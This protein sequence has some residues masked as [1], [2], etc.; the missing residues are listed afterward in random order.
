MVIAG[1]LGSLVH[2]TTSFVS[3]VGNRSFRS[4]WILWYYLRPLVGIGIALIFYFLLRGGLLLVSTVPD[5][6]T[7][8]NPFGIAA[9]VSLAGMFSKQATDKLSEVFDSLFK[10]NVDQER[11]DKLFDQKP[12]AAEMIKR[13][14]IQGVRL[15]E[16]QTEANVSIWRLYQQLSPQVTRLP[17]FNENGALNCVIHQSLLYKFIS[18]KS[19]QAADSDEPLTLAG[20]QAL[21]LQDFLDTPRMRAMTRD[22]VAFVGPHATLSEAKAAMAAIE[23]CQDVFVTDDGGRSGKV[24]GWLTN[25]ILAKLSSAGQG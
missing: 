9:I 12:A 13:S 21:T 7:G 4:S 11:G 24:L 17:V 23:G 18:E 2:A 20:L 15:E 14:E 3:Y 6:R 22:A 1:A 8:I 5:V 16:G 10:S 19:V 25:G